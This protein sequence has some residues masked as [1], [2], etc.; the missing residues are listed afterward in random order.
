MVTV[1][2][3]YGSDYLVN[4][5]V[6]DKGSRVCTPMFLLWEAGED[7]FVSVVVVLVK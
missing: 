3:R 7:E 6:K 1:L 2:V 5:L 4:K